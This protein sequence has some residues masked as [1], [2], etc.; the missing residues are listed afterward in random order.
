VN[1]VSFSPN[2]RRIATGS[3]DGTVKL[4]DTASGAEVF[5]LR[6]HTSGVLC[7]AFSPNGDQLVSGSIDF[8]VRV[9]DATP[10][11]PVRE[12]EALLKQPAPVKRNDKP[13]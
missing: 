13:E 11:T 9:W 7:V 1:S 2:G 4:W 6:G 8:T 5:T 10:L 12:A 3:N